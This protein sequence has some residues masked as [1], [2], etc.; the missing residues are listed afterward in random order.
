[1][2]VLVLVDDFSKVNFVS[3]FLNTEVYYFYVI[4]QSIYSCILLF[5]ENSRILCLLQWVKLFFLKNSGK[6]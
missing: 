5:H 6:L 2:A 1:M 3:V 4:A